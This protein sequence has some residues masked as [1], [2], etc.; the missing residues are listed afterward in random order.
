MTQYAPG[1]LRR[2]NSVPGRGKRG[3]DPSEPPG[4][5]PSAGGSARG[6]Q[7]MKEAWDKDVK[8]SSHPKTFHWDSFLDGTA[9]CKDKIT[10]L[11]WHQV[12]KQLIL[13]D[14]SLIVKMSVP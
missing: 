3:I 14:T 6:D 5:C 8:G 11:P 13:L 1:I 7:K 4:V 12:T 10:D 9:S 2:A